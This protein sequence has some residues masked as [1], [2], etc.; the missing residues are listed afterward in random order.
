MLPRSYFLEIFKCKEWRI[1]QQTIYLTLCILGKISA[2][3][4]LKYIFLIIF[5]QKIRFDVSCK[6]LAWNAK[7]CSQGKI[8]KYI[9]NLSYAELTTSPVKLWSAMSAN[10]GECNAKWQTR[11][12]SFVSCLF[13]YPYK[14]VVLGEIG[15]S[16]DCWLCNKLFCGNHIWPTWEKCT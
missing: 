3:D 5:I 2:Y 11:D 4:I 1:Q 8:R 7:A 13:S 15:Y 9:I 6:L 10:V 14:D 12:T 16:V